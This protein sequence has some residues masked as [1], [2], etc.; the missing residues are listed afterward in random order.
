MAKVPT[1]GIKKRFH[2]NALIIAANNIGPN[3]VKRLIIKIPSKK[4][5]P[6]AR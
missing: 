4:T 5:K 3:D 6:T 2:T 1:G